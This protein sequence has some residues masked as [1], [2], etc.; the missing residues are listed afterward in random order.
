[1]PC[2]RWLVGGLS[3]HRS[4]FDPSSV[5]VRFVVDKVELILRLSPVSIIPS[6]LQTRLHTR[7]ALTRRTKGRS[8]GT[9]LKTTVFGKSGCI[10]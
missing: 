5:H 6:M 7:V 3:P 2:F 4:G 8:V 1:M 10:G 9:F